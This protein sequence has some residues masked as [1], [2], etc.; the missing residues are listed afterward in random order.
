MSTKNTIGWL[1]LFSGITIIVLSLY[2]SWNVFSGRT[3]PPAIFKS[4]KIKPTAAY[5]E[6]SATGQIN[7]QREAEK[8]IGKQLGGMIPTGTIPKTLNLAVQSGLVSIFIFAGSQIA[9][10]GIKMIR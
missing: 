9:G 2:Y 7:L 3:S 5:P 4:N 8:A 10:L 1:L 6:N